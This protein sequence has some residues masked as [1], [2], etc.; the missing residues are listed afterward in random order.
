VIAPVRGRVTCNGRPVAQ[1]SL[2]FSP[3]P[4]SDEDQQPGK[5]AT[6]FTDAEG[7]YVLS[8]YKALDG[9]R[10][11]PHRVTITLDDTNP[12][13]CQRLT[14]LKLEV[15]RGRNELDIELK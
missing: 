14:H 10:V 8:T 2:I 3:I 11:G 5:P 12:A 4:S 1:A 7:N 9:A 6:G 15:A 13:R